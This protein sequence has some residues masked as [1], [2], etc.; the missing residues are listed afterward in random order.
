MLDHYDSN[1]D[2]RL[3]LEEFELFVRDA[4]R[5]FIVVADD[6][7][8]PAPAQGKASRLRRFFRRFTGRR[9]G[10]WGFSS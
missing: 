6:D 9:S 7:T 8:K 2:G 10:A 5:G 1:P 3:D 4:S